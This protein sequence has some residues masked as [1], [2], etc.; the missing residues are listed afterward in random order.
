MMPHNP[1]YYERLFDAARFQKAKDLIA[2]RGGWQ[3]EYLPVPE[4][5][6]RGTELMK[7]R[8]GVSMRPLDLANFKAK[9]TRESLPTLLEGVGLRA[10][11]RPRD[12]PSRGAVRQSST[13]TWSHS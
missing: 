10:D 1:P 9:W 4:R 5:T 7:K 13:Q 2:M 8:L 6:V 11:D 3:A 12:R